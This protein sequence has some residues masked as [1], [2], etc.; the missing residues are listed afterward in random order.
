MSYNLWNANTAK[1]PQRVHEV[2]QERLPYR[3]RERVICGMV[4]HSRERV[5]C[6]FCSRLRER[7]EV[8]SRERFGSRSHKRCCSRERFRFFFPGPMTSMSRGIMNTWCRYRGEYISKWQKRLSLFPLHQKRWQKPGRLLIS[9]PVSRFLDHQES[10]ASLGLVVALLLIRLPEKM[11][12]V[13]EVCFCL[14]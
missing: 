13:K 2:I 12:T 9:Y 8:R 10:I 4:Y 3:S 6:R 7:L 1:S 11:V 14:I 5:W